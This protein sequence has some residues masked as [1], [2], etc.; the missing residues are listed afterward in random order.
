MKE[1]LLGIINEILEN[2][3][4]KAINEISNGVSLRK[5]LGFDSLDLAVLTVTV[6]D[7]FGVDI[8]ENGNIDTIEEILG[9]LNYE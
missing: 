4:R 3:N 1:K 2:E 7:E 8:F 6:E 9:C 5:D